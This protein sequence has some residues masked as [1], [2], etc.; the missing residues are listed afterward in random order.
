MADVVQVQAAA[1]SFVAAEGRAKLVF[2]VAIAFSLTVFGQGAMAFLHSQR[3]TL[4]DAI[5]L[6][7][8]RGNL[9]WTTGHSYLQQLHRELYRNCK[10]LGMRKR[11]TN[12]V[13]CIG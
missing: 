11:I 6:G 5:C 10:L 3:G 12:N 13:S 7:W 1:L 2:G 4:L 9:N 8:Y